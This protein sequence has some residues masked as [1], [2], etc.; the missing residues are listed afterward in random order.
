MALIE[1]G[2]ICIVTKGRDAGK[3]V[4]IKEVIDKNFVNIVGEKV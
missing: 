2:R 1:P 4:V 3:E